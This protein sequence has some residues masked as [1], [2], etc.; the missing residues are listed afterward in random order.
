VNVI[1]LNF[2]ATDQTFAEI[3][4]YAKFRDDRSNRCSFRRVIWLLTPCFK[5]IG[6]FTFIFV[7]LFFVFEFIRYLTL[8]LI[9]AKFKI[10][11]PLRL[12]MAICIVVPYFMAIGQTIAE[13]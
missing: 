1:M 11:T 6:L 9:I 10:F 5:L 2:M 3:P 7:F 12:V 4:H 8:S 13:I